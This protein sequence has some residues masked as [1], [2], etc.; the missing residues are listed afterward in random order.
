MKKSHAENYLRRI[1]VSNNEKKNGTTPT[2]RSI[3]SSLSRRLRTNFREAGVGRVKQRQKGK[4]P[5]T[6]LA[7]EHQ[8]DDVGAATPIV[9]PFTPSPTKRK[10]TSSNQSTQNEPAKQFISNHF[11]Y[12]SHE[13]DFYSPENDDPHLCTGNLGMGR[14]QIGGLFDLEDNTPVNVVIPFDHIED[15]T[16]VINMRQKVKGA[17]ANCAKDYHRSLFRSLRSDGVRLKL[18]H[19][20]QQHTFTREGSPYCQFPATVKT[21][22]HRFDYKTWEQADAEK[23]INQGGRGTRQA[24]RRGHC[25]HV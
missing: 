11:S 13:D 24:S 5:S 19:I 21:V 7:V 16:E 15:T 12:K 2:E 10:K 20:F 17:I 9:H 8:D 22:P 23:E 14:V 6:R 25:G 18:E 1:F 3:L 4:R